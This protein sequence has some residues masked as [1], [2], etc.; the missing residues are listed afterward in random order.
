MTST[1]IGLIQHGYGQ[2]F[3][4]L[5]VVWAMQTEAGLRTH[6]SI[7]PRVFKKS[8]GLPLNGEELSRNGIRR[9]RNEKFGLP[10]E[11]LRKLRALSTPARIQHFI[12][13]LP[14]QYANTAWSPQRALQV[15][16]YSAVGKVFLNL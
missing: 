7:I 14:Y 11:T 12:D 1:L 10:P 3:V 2:D 5:S 4:V 16:F 6:F 15:Y 9:D 13:A 8:C